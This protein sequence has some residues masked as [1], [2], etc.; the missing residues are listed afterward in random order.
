[1]SDALS[2]DTVQQSLDAK[3]KPPGSL[4]RLD[5]IAKTVALVQQTLRPDPD[6][7][8]TIVFAGD[9]GVAGE[10]VS[11]YPA[12]V[13]P[14][15]V[16]TMAAGTAAISVLSRTFG[17]ANEIVDVGVNADIESLAGVV[18]AKVGPGTKNFAKEPAMTASECR[19]AWNIGVDAA[20]RAAD[21]GAKTIILGEVG[22][23][24]TTSAAAILAAV[25]GWT[26]EQSVGRGTG[27]DDAGLAR[28]IDVVRAG[29]GHVPHGASAMAVLAAVGGFEIAAMAGAFVGAKE[30]GIVAVVDGFIATAAATVAVREAPSVA[31]HLV[32]GHVSAE[33]AHR[34]ALE[35]L[36]LSPILDLELR[37]GEGT[38][39][40][41]AIPQIRAACAVLREMATLEDVMTS[42]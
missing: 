25:H 20:K 42:T 4:G 11:A 40:V 15:M 6:P 34:R 10:G 30:H 12:E 35:A 19:A 5:A 9:H 32:A 14:A 38:G 16:R 18:H 29:L 28:K 33:A 31:A 8:R 22:I 27:V 7:A 26:P 13:T 21:A 1:M 17:I 3:A 37:L 41:L 39:A 24:N 2:A 23:G 36:A